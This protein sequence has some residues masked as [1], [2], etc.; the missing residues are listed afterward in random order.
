MTRKY[1]R[2]NI[3]IY[4]HYLRR[5]YNMSMSQALTSVWR[6]IKTSPAAR[7]TID[8][9]AAIEISF[10]AKNPTG[11]IKV[12]QF[13]RGADV[14]FTAGGKTYAYTNYG[15]QEKLGVTSDMPLTA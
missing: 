10:K 6:Q 4:A 15:W 14:Q 11:T 13:W 8:Q 9:K 1:N 12:R 3:F 5:K 7:V 2:R